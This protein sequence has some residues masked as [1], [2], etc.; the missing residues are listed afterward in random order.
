MD[1]V[2]A[3]VTRESGILLRSNCWATVR[4][5]AGKREE[6][7]IPGHFSGFSKL[8]FNLVLWGAAAQSP[9]AV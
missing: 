2:A 8:T 7:E 9:S 6:G 4:D 1:D 3:A 5:A